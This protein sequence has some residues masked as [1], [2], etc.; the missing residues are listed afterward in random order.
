MKKIKSILIAGLAGLLALSCA[1]EELVMFDAS[2]ATAPVL[3]SYVVTDDDVTVDFT[4]G[5]F[6]QSFNKNMP[7]NHSIILKTVNGDAVGN[8]VPSALKDG[9]L[10]VTVANLS[11]ALIALGYEEGNL[12]DIEMVIR[13][14][15]QETA[16]D[17]GKNGFVESQGVISIQDYEIFLPTGDPYAR[18]TEKSVWSLVGSFNSWGSEPDIEMWTNG[19]LHVAKE[20]ELSAGTEV[21]FRKDN[22]WDVNFGYG[23]GVESYT[24]DEEFAVAQDG[25][26]IVIA[27]TGVYYLLLDP[28]AKKAKVIA[29]SAG[30]ED[31][32]DIDLSSYEENDA[33]AGAGTW[34]IIGPAVLDWNTDVDLE[35][36]SDNPEIWAAKNIPFQE[37]KFKFRGNDEWADY[38]LGGAPEFALNTPLQL[39]KGGGDIAAVAGVYNVYLYPTYMLVY[40]TEGSGDVPPPPAKP[41]AWSLIGTIGGSGWDKDFDLENVT[42]DKWVIKNVTINEGEEFKI[43]ADHDWSKSYGGPEAND[44]STVD[45]NDPYGVYRPEIGTEFVAGGTN[46]RIPATGAYNVTLNYGEEPTILIEEYKEF[47]DALYMIGSDFGGWDWGSD[48]IVELVPVVH[49]PGWGAEAE[50]Q[51]WTVRYFTADNGFKFN[52]AKAWD[53]GQFGKLGTNEGFTNDNDDNLHVPADGLYLV[54]IDMKRSILHVEP[55][56]VY[57]IGSCFGGWNEGMEAAL[58]QA[59]GKTLKATT[60]DEGELRMY[61]ASDI[62]TSDWWT[63]EFI[64]LD[65]KIDY[66]GDDEGQGDQERV[67]VLKGQVVTLDFNAGTGTITG[68]GEVPDKPAAWS[69]VGTL[70]G[71]EWGKDFDLEN[72]SGD[73]WVIKK[74]EIKEADEFKIRADH[75]WTKSVGGPEGN[76]HSTIKEDDPYE[77]YKPEIGKA[78]ETGDKNIR[79]G[80][81]GTYTITFDYKANTILIEE[82]QEFPAALYMVGQDFGGWDWSSEGV[83]SLTPVLHNPE[84]GADA[85]GQFWTIRYLKAGNGF[86]INAARAW[87]GGQFGKLETNEGFTNDGDENIQVAEDGVYMIHVDLKR[88]ILH[89]EPAKVYGIGNCFGGWDEAMG[90]ALFEAK[91]GKLSAELKADGDLR[92]YVSSAISTSGWWTREFNAVDGKIVFRLMEELAA[93]PAKAGQTVTL[94]FNAGT[95]VVE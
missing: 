90:A 14:S 5:S 31:L 18:Y 60:A 3:Q 88:G 66:R 91:D 46:I 32:P 51:F 79:I 27:E 64:I 85:P 13:A 23:E 35:K 68:E 84:W 34:G 45:P 1:Q 17:N 95:A 10:V 24:L 47:P 43:R 63:R 48:G 75:A 38:D 4:P 54:H 53:G 33:M 36:V 56:R 55:A 42:G 83:V 16:R 25:P 81:E 44:Q 19:T 78:F 30:G 2:K 65:G 59:D 94:D 49:N 76:D 12:V 58:F 67:K 28:E 21:K 82:Y 26:N 20:V 77:V 62:K 87:D 37:D 73:L 70:E 9:K 80:V 50:G 71:S 52:S 7:V 29:A 57:G 86:K 93:V 15:M 89:V 22:S 74:V 61:V 72:T 69:L 11:K 39:S 41:K 6:G 40:L 92:M 8:A